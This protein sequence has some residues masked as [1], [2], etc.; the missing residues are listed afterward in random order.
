MLRK[1]HSHSKFRYVGSIILKS[2]LFLADTTCGSNLIEKWLLKAVGDLFATIRLTLYTSYIVGLA[3]PPFLFI[4]Y[5]WIKRKTILQLFL[6]CYIYSLGSKTQNPGLESPVTVNPCDSYTK[7]ACQ[8][9]HLGCFILPKRRNF[10]AKNEFINA[11]ETSELKDKPRGYE[12]YWWP[13]VGWNFAKSMQAK[14]R[15]IEIIN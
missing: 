10:L 4:L 15:G 9:W 8:T 13:F 6:C 14:S 12:E 7:C 5:C 11:C 1:N 2:G 3:W